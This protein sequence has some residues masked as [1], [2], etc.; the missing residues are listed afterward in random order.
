MGRSKRPGR[1]RS[2]S[3]AQCPKTVHPWEWFGHFQPKRGKPVTFPGRVGPMGYRSRFA[4]AL[5]TSRALSLP[6]VALSTRNSRPD[7]FV[8]RLGK[9]RGSAPRP[10]GRG[11]GKPRIDGAPPGLWPELRIP[12]IAAPAVPGG[13]LVCCRA[14]ACLTSIRVLPLGCE[15]VL[16]FSKSRGYTCRSIALGSSVPP[17]VCIFSAGLCSDLPQPGSMGARSGRILVTY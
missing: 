6:T 5:G 3:G 4:P 14:T 15:P 12:R 11:V 9:H 8:F 1:L 10:P 2:G 16:M 7:R 17:P 13:G